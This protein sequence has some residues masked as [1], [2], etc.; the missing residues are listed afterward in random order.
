MSAS[1]RKEPPRRR[2]T[3][4]KFSAKQQRCAI[5]RALRVEGARWRRSPPATIKDDLD[6]PHLAGLAAAARATYGPSVN[7]R[8]VRFPLDR[9]LW[10]R[11]LDPE[12]GHALLET[13]AACYDRQRCRTVR[14]SLASVRLRLFGA[15]L[16]R[17]PGQSR[18]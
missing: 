15:G 13:P 12:D 17:V 2:E 4:P 10:L 18:R 6:Y 3:P 7:W 5:L 16:A 11:V 1:S 8:G 14:R 9:G